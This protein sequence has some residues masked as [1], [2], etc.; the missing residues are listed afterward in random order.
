MREKPPYRVAAQL[1]SRAYVAALVAGVYTIR[2]TKAGKVIETK[3]T[4]GL[5]RRVS[6]EADRKAQFDAAMKVHA[7]FGAES[8]LMD[9]ILPLRAA[10]AKAV[11]DLPEGEELHK[12]L[13]DFDGSGCGAETDCRDNGRGCDHRRGTIART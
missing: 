1:A 9:R 12:T 3:L 11:A 2:L 4:I 8:A 10:L 7:L 13:T 5:D 6:I